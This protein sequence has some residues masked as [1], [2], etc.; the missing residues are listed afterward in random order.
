MDEA[1]YTP[2]LLIT[3]R[4]A[5]AMLGCDAKT[6]RHMIRAGTI[7]A[8]AG[9]KMLRRFDVEAFASSPVSP[10]DSNG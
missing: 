3:R 1:V 5:A 9:T 6:L 8:V 10:S 2:P 7:P 4:R